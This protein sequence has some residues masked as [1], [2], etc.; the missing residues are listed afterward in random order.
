MTRTS[1]WSNLGTDVVGRTSLDEVLLA[2]ELDYTVTAND[3]YTAEGKIIPG[4]KVTTRDTDGKI[5]G[6]VGDKYKVCQN[7]DAFDFVNYISE[8]IK[9]IKAGETVGGLVYIIAELPEVRVLGDTF[10]PNVIFSNGHNGGFSVRTAIVPL[11]IVCQNQ[12]N[13]AFREANNTI[14]IRHMSSLDR[15]LEEAR[16]VMVATADYMKTLTKVAEKYAMIKLSEGDISTLMLDLFPVTE[17][18]GKRAANTM[19]DR[20]AEFMRAYNEDDNTDYRGT[21]WGLVNASSDYIT[22]I[23][24]SRK[25]DNWEDNKFTNVTFDPRFMTELLEKIDN[26]K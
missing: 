18:T 23:D 15:R 20:R 24:P 4:V 25:S 13:V 1:T 14:S 21:A 17:S 3:I 6:V 2:S 12:F 7:R 22:H 5:Y 11:R 10:K 19:M 16:E 8:D 26:L 9:F